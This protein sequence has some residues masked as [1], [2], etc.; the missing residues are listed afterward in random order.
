MRIALVQSN[1]V[2][3]D[4]DGNIARL[5]SLCASVRADIYVLPE[6][7]YT[8]YQFVSRDEVRDLSDELSSPRIAEIYLASQELD[9]TII[10]GFAERSGKD[11]YN[12]ALAVLPNGQSFLYRKTHLFYKEVLFFQQG[13]TGFGVFEFR[14]A[15]IGIAICFDWFFPESFR[16]LALKGADIIAHCSNLV[17]PYCQN[18]NFAAAVQN[19]IFIATANRVGSEQREIEKLDFTGQSVLVSPKGEYLIRGPMDEETVMVA[20]IDPQ[21]ARNKAINSYNDVFAM[22]RPELYFH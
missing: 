13:N 15:R 4:P 19:R 9:A 5:L 10:F 16:S 2:F 1:P 3:G 17:L 6:L 18:A 21:E 12:A 20:E 14:G 11:I 22:R 8:G 7:C